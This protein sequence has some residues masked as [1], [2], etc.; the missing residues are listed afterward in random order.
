MTLHNEIAVLGDILDQAVAATEQGSARLRIERV[1]SE[2]RLV[3]FTD[4]DR[5]AQVFINLIAN[6]QKYCDATAP[7]LRIKVRDGARGLS[8]D[9]IDNGTGIPKESQQ[10]IFEKFSRLGDTRAAGGAGLGLAICREI[11]G[12][13]GGSLTYLPGQGGAAFRVT[14]PNRLKPA[15]PRAAE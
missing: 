1:P 15:Q 10:V 14:L 6:A 11:A 9:F 4:R 5:L 13:L 3:L 7:L 2:E 8:V 12:R